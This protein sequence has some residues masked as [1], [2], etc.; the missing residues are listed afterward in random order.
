MAEPDLLLDKELVPIAQ[1][2]LPFPFKANAPFPKAQLNPPVVLLNV[3]TP[4]ALLLLL[5]LF[6]RAFTPYPVL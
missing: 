5:V 1:F 4:K 2:N 3:P 6:F